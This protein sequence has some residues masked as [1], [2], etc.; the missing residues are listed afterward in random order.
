M[1]SKLI[2]SYSFY[3]I[4]F[5]PILLVTGPFLADLSV[6]I[7]NIIFFYII[8]KE[9]NFDLFKNKYFLAFVLFCLYLIIRSIFTSNIGVS[10]KSVLFYFRFIIFSLMVYLTIKNYDNFFEKFSII[11][12]ILINFI[13]ID[14]LIQYL[15]GS[16]I[17]G[18]SS[19]HPA[20]VSGPFGDE[21]VLGSFLSRFSPFLLFFFYYKKS[22]FNYLFL[23]TFLFGF[24]ITLLS[25]E[26]AG[27]IFYILT[28][29]FFLVYSK[30]HVKTKISIIILVF[31]SSVLVLKDSNH[32]QRLITETLSNSDNGRFVFSKMHHTHYKTAISI[33]LDKPYFGIGPKMFRYHCGDKKYE[34]KNPAWSTQNLFRCSSHPHNLFLQLMSETGII[35]IIF[36]IIIFLYVV[37]KLSNLFLFQFF[38]K[39][40][41]KNK[42]NYSIFFLL[43]FFITLWPIAPSGSFFNNWSSII[44]FY[45]LGFYLFF[46]EKDK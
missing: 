13:L 16:D 1:Q 36:Y 24:F 21:L 29:L 8:F 10:L 9:K 28:I 22:P 7:L 45:P 27:S 38:N 39:N 19:T 33:F 34:I 31:L 18:I 43:A 26:R 23:L 4:A 2:Y 20:R 3:L 42:D 37:F 30:K 12:I 14:S 5:M 11:F 6:V 46:L 32:K 35:G 15:F 17:F 44:F 41:L 25:A 40:N